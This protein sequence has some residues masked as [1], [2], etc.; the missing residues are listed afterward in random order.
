MI[1]RITAHLHDSEKKALLLRLTDPN[2]NNHRIAKEFH[3]NAM[4][5]SILRD[6]FSECYRLWREEKLVL[7]ERTKEWKQAQSG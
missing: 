3:L 6:N 1:A 5:V 4:A 7:I 2:S